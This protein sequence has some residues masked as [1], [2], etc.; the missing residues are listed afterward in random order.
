MR[1]KSTNDTDGKY[2]IVHIYKYSK[3]SLYHNKNN[4]VT[5][6]I[7]LISLHRLRAGVNVITDHTCTPGQTLDLPGC[8]ECIEY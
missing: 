6:H 4:L 2:I 3:L 5:C 8:V 7:L 1:N